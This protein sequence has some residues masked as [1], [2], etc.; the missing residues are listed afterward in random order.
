METFLRSNFT[1][2]PFWDRGGDRGWVPTTVAKKASRGGPLVLAISAQRLSA[3]KAQLK[4]EDI[5]PFFHSVQGLQQQL[6]LVKGP[7]L[8]PIPRTLVVLATVVHPNIVWEE[9]G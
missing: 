5:S 8:G 4:E 3:A 2:Q 1:L 7:L 9:F 6:T